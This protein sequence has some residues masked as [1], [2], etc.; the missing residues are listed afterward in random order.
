VPL[1][2][3]SF[4][5][6]V[7][8]VHIAAVVLAFGVTFSFPI[9]LGVA[10][11]RYE[12]HMGFYHR[13]QAL[14]G[15]RLIGP[16]GG[17]VLLAGLYLAIKGPYEFGDPWIGITLLLLII[18]L[19]VGGGYVGPREE[20]LAEMAERDVAASPGEGAVSFGQDYEHLFTQV[21]NVTLALNALILIAI[22]LMVTKPG[23]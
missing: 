19:G 23:A 15:S 2:E 17:L 1:A 7:L 12:R 5:N 3:I 11:Q 13:V 8:F 4:Y 16:L 20:R 22:F 21:R 18:I 14:I 9:V 6:V 10:R